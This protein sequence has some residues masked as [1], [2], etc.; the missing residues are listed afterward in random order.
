[1]VSVNVGVAIGAAAEAIGAADG[2]PERLTPKPAAV[3]LKPAKPQERSRFLNLNIR[4]LA[5]LTIWTF[6]KLW[7]TST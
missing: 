6:L 5:D 1:M 7:T 3:T 2:K 4:T